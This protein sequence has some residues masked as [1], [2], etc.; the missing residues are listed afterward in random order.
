MV[1]DK[2]WI[3]Y[4]G[5]LKRFEPFS[6]TKT[7]L[8]IVWSKSKPM[9]PLP[10]SVLRPQNAAPQSALNDNDL[11]GFR[12]KQMKSQKKMLSSGLLSTKIKKT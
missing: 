5:C 6:L 3:L 12:I 9:V 11:H 4:K 2:E 1:R 10:Q 8:S 7:W